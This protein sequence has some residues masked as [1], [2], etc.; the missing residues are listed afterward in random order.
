M[1]K[2]TA[3]DSFNISRMKG[4]ETK[5]EAS[6]ECEANGSHDNTQVSVE[7]VSDKEDDDPKE[8]SSD[9]ETGLSGSNPPEDK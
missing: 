3:I 7:K 6:I 5:R 4:N 8:K 1:N 9:D 2:Q